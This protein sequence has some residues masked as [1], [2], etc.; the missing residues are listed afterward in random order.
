MVGG[1]GAVAKFYRLRIVCTYAM[2]YRN[3]RSAA[4]SCTNTICAATKIGGVPAEY[5][6]AISIFEFSKYRWRLLNRN[7]PRDISSQDTM[8]SGKF[9]YRMHP[10]KFT[11]VR[12]CLRRF[13]FRAAGPRCVLAV[14]GASRDGATATSV[15]LAPADEADSNVSVRE[16]RV[17]NASSA[18]KL[19]LPSPA[20]VAV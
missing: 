15:L 19:P 2:P 16:R 4:S 9:W 17:G 7:P 6:A 8:S 11:L 20:S 1:W 13:S 14:T 10:L 12:T 5:G 18:T 3:T